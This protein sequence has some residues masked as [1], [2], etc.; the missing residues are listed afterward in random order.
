M[1][2]VYG[3][4]DVVLDSALQK[5]LY[6]STAPESRESLAMSRVESLAVFQVRST[7]AGLAGAAQSNGVADGQA[8]PAEDKPPQVRC[9]RRVVTSCQ[10]FFKGKY[11]KNFRAR[12]S[13]LTEYSTF[14]FCIIFF[15]LLNTLFMALE[16]HEMDKDLQKAVNIVNLVS[17]AVA[18]YL[19][20]LVVRSISSC[21][22]FFLFFFYF[23]LFSIFSIFYFYFE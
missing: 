17:L 4:Q 9:P 2:L 8:S 21:H 18:G 14:D 20:V 15:I 12:V 16:H 5:A 1:S 7:N 22:F 11:W 13:K 23:L 3:Q 6:D 19:N 10:A